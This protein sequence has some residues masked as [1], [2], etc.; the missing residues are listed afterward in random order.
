[1]IEGIISRYTWV[2]YVSTGPLV[3]GSA[4]GHSFGRIMLTLFKVSQ[5]NGVTRTEKVGQIQKTLFDITVNEAGKENEKTY[6]DMPFSLKLE[7]VILQAQTGYF[8]EVKFI[9][10][11]E[12]SASLGSTISGH[13]G[14]GILGGK[15]DSVSFKN[16]SVENQR[17]FTIYWMNISYPIAVLSN[18]NIISAFSF[19]QTLKQISFNLVGIS[20]THSFCNVTIPKT[21]MEGEPWTV[22]LNGTNWP[23]TQTNNETHS[24]IYFN[25]TH[26]STYEVIIQGT[27]VVP[28]FSSTS[29]FALFM[30]TTLTAIVL[31]KAKRK[32][33]LKFSPF[34]LKPRERLKKSHCSNR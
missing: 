26:A 15:V 5:T 1:V 25:Y 32:Y 17:I 9:V 3:V 4:S 20:G 23:F 2:V 8:V 11:T 33:K 24:F 28:E 21:L 19:N 10:D 13:A 18:S 27:W 16:K 29:I 12:A 30:T 31:L 14:G 34:K 22:K 7:D 6:D